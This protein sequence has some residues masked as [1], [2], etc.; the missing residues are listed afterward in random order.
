[1]MLCVCWLTL[2]MLPSL[3][4]LNQSIL[5]LGARRAYTFEAPQRSCPAVVQQCWTPTRGGSEMA[6][7]LLKTEPSE[8]S[9]ANLSL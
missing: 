6:E 5:S 7:Y 9:F 4:H 2:R 1:M 8:Y 3:N